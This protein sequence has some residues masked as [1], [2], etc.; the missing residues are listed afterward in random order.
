MCLSA[1]AKYIEMELTFLRIRAKYTEL[2]LNVWSIRAKY[3]RNGGK[4]VLGK[5]NQN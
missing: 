5:N 2:K 3:I 1:R 4:Y